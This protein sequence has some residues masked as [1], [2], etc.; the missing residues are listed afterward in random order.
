M[1]E[2]N[3]C[4]PVDTIQQREAANICCQQSYWDFVYF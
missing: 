1:V 4:D 3:Y 2:L